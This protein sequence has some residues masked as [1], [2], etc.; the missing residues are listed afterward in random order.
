M[1]LDEGHQRGGVFAAGNHL[2]ELVDQRIDL[3]TR[4]L[5]LSG[6][7]E[8]LD[9][10][11]HVPVGERRWPGACPCFSLEKA[12]KE[13]HFLPEVL[14]KYDVSNTQVLTRFRIQSRNRQGLTLLSAC[15]V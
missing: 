6:R 13:V 14:L 3:V 15:V 1:V 2:G 9:D 8:L 11:L 12:L 10:R 7:L 4:N 5:V